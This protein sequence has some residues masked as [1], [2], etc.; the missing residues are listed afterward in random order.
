MFNK[1]NKAFFSRDVLL[2]GKTAK[3]LYDEV[4]SLP[5]IDYHCHLDPKAI[6]E[7]AFIGD[8][9]S[10][11]LDCD[12]YK[13]RA[14][15][16][17]GV[18]E[19]YITG[20]ASPKEKFIRYAE[21]MPKLC[22][23]PLYYWTHLELKLLFG[24]NEPLCARSAERIYN[25][26][27]AELKG[28]TVTDLLSRFDVRY[29]ATTDD[30]LDDLCYH[31]LHCGVTVAPTFRPDKAL[32]LD[33]RYLADLEKK[34]GE[35]TSSV[36]GFIRALAKRMDYFNERGCKISDHGFEQFPKKIISHDEA[37][38]LYAQRE[39]LSDEERS[40]LFGYLLLSLMR[41]Y[42]KRDMVVQLHFGVTRNVN[43]EAFVVVGADSGYDVMSTP[44]DP[45]GLI[46]FLS[47]LTD[48]E[49]PEILLYTLNL[50]C[51]RNRCV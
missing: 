49:R 25:R 27:T 42:K 5:I 23:N 43:K 15:R 12:H 35:S 6:A 48:A 9:G 30:P 51:V 28:K 36:D 2:S 18:D 31:G 17:C 37:E 4:K 41:E 47:S 34:T 39:S 50:A 33:E 44:P 45:K 7:D 1:R 46:E 32:S 10:M 29:I 8:I 24:I 40:A 13:W 3:K 26:A 21:I 14:M 16:L 19:Y 11:W 22:G 20:G 38:F